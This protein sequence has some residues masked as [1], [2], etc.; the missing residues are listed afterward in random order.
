[1]T[2]TTAALLCFAS[3]EEHIDGKYNETLRNVVTTKR[4]AASF[5]MPECCVIEPLRHLRQS[6]E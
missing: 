5:S 6:E 3:I 4:K 1:M 2:Q